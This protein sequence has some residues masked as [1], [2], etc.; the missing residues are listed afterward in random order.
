MSTVDAP[1]AQPNKQI[2]LETDLRQAFWNDDPTGIWHPR[3]DIAM[4]EL[5]LGTELVFLSGRQ[6]VGK[7]RQFARLLRDRLAAEG[8]GFYYSRP[9]PVRTEAR[10]VIVDEMSAPL[11]D[12]EFTA[13]VDSFECRQAVLLFPG[14]TRAI[15]LKAIGRVLDIARARRG[16]PSAAHIDDIPEAYIETD[17]AVELLQA[18]GAKDSLIEYV[19]AVAA[20]RTPRLFNSLFIK[21]KLTFGREV[22]A[23]G[24]VEMVL[25]DATTAEHGY[26]AT[27]HVISELIGRGFAFKPGRHLFFESV[28][29]STRQAIELYNAAGQ[30]LPDPDSFDINHLH[31]DP[32]QK[33]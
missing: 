13:I 17:R 25:Q 30:P 31:F 26:T 20:L 10:T 12:E 28:E 15:R 32:Y 27:Y 19:Q 9:R 22:A 16:Q 11:P 18:L 8:S 3:V 2:Q 21:S 5:A 1:A 33:D 14:A 4:G 7:S 6:G 23:K 29:L 24:D